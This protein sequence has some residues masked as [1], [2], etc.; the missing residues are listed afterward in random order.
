MKAIVKTAPGP[1]NVAYTDFPDPELLPG[2]ALIEVR[3]AGLCGTDLSLYKWTDS[4][5]GQFRPRIPVVMGHEFAGVVAQVG[6]GVTGLHAGDRVTAN[7]IMYCGRCYYCKAGRQSIC[8]DRPLLGLGLN[9][10]FA[11]FVTVRQENIYLLPPEV[12]FEAGAMSEILCVALHALERVSVGPGDTV[13]V[14]GPGPLG[15]LVLL[16]ARAA[17]ASRL[18]L[19]GLAADSDRL[20]VAASLGAHAIEVDATDPAEAV[21]GLT[22]GLGA[23]VA[24]ECS[25]HPS[26]VPQ[27]L[28]LVRKGGKIGVLGM[29]NAD[30][31]FNTAVLSYREVEMVG[32]RAYDP[33]TWHRSRDVL[34]SRQ[35]PL[36]ILITHRLPL[37]EAARGIELMESRQ[38]LKIMFTPDWI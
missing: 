31:S 6:P 13:V 7:P 2:H 29:G 18:I 14:V 33:T 32:I 11:R 1:G 28:G 37:Q 9:G 8:E 22:R 15:F 10:C 27:A 35:F 5:A 34:V 30:S 21:R 25:G 38:G 19:T 24:F 20:K 36:E 17:G 26:G 23:D 4:M 12:S 3:A 16:A